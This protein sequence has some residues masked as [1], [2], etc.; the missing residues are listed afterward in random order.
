MEKTIIKKVVKD[1]KVVGIIINGQFIKV[2]DPD[3]CNDINVTYIAIY[4]NHWYNTFISFAP[5]K[6]KLYDQISKHSLVSDN[7]TEDTMEDLERFESFPYASTLRQAY[8]ADIYCLD[9]P[10]LIAHTEKWDESIIIEE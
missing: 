9:I 7:A 3:D 4:K 5:D 10:C 6:I 2:F 1:Y 8:N